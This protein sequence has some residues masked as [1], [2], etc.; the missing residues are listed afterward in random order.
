M[1]KNYFKTAW[2]SIWKNTTISVINIVGLSVG[3]TAAML[4]FLWVNNEMNFDNYH[5][6][7]GNIF[8][9]T[10][11]L[12]ADN[13][14]WETSPL[15][16]ADAVKKEVPGIKD[17]VRLYDGN[18][19][20]FTVNNNPAYEKKCAYVDNS[21]FTLFHYDFIEGNASAFAQDDHSI[22]LTASAAKKYFGNRNAL[23]ASI[24]VDSM[25]Y[26][27]KGV[28]KDPRPNS[29]FQYSSFMPLAALLK[30]PDR[31]ANDEQW[32]NANY[33]TFIKTVKG[34]DE[35][36]VSSKITNIYKSKS[37]DKETSI[38]LTG[39]R[40]MH[41]E[42]DVQSSVFTHGNKITVYVFTILGFLLLLIAC[43]NYVNL[44]TAKASLRA[45]EVSVRK[46]IGA[47]RSHL[48]LQFVLESFLIS[49][50]SL[51][52]TLL[53]IQLCLP[54]F[55]IVTGKNFGLPLTSLSMWQIIGITL[56]FALLLNSIYPA[57]V[58]S[59]FKPLNVFRGFTILKVKDSYFRKVLVTLQFTISV[60][61][62]TG[63]VIIYK[64]MQFIQ[65]TNPGYNRSQVVSFPLP[66]DVGNENKNTLVQTIRQSL[67]AHSSIQNVTVANQSIVNIGSMSTG[68]ADWD[69]H[70]TSY[71]PKIAQLSTDAAFANT[72][73]LQMKEGRWFMEGNES[74]KNNV[75]VNEEAVADLHIHKPVIGQRFSFKGRQGQVIGVV[76]DFNYKSMHDKSGPLV[77]FNDPNWFR[78]FLVRIAPNNAQKAI[79]EIQNTWKQFL[80]G[81]P[82]EY[83]FLDDSFNELYSQDQQT[84]SLI[85][86]FAIIAI[87]ISCLGLFGLAAFTAEQR[88][89]EIGIRKVLGA[90]IANITTLISKDFVKLV[91]IAIIIA[92]PISLMAMN[93]WLQNFQ[94]KINIGWWMFALSGLI[95]LCIALLTISFQAIKA[96]IANP[97]KSLRTE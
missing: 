43:I 4:I 35:S 58:L 87:A 9:L 57:L 5:N 24:R 16:L 45:K 71:N 75:V 13:W 79:A 34:A 15:L 32:Q 86:A 83:T 27:V 10:T 68:S 30:D 74:D 62:I 37:G 36:L 6:D 8:R 44:T 53:L 3:M 67:L 70:D 17:A 69:G 26:V 23:G 81:R 92:T 39:L 12:K 60:M 88:I 59:S 42:N 41:F 52:A 90:T 65:S 64:Q 22:I 47:K 54:V 56:F 96:A 85:F 63:T 18:W 49:L 78:F 77:A 84:S 31:R 11:N 73:Q 14:V 7:S 50:L 33:I 20:V 38:S 46:M 21:W 95:A 61:L 29:S 1:L 2:R 76:K 66:A 51:V 97:V 93:S 28:I 91:C 48:F 89:K 94:Y 55:N 19:P 40:D 72:L 25:D 82:L 80:P